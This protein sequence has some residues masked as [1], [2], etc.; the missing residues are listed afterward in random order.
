MRRYHLTLPD[1]DSPM[2]RWVMDLA[3]MLGV[4]YDPNAIADRLAA[5]T[6]RRDSRLPGPG[7]E[8]WRPHSDSAFGQ[9]L[10]HLS[11]F[12]G[13]GEAPGDV[14]RAVFALADRAD[15]R[16]CPECGHPLVEHDDRVAVASGA[17]AHGCQWERRSAAGHRIVCGCPRAFPDAQARDRVHALPVAVPADA[18]VAETTA[19]EPVVYLATTEDAGL[20]DTQGVSATRDG[21]LALLGAAWLRHTANGAPSGAV[22]HLRALGV[23]DPADRQTP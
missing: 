22:P 10:A 11:L 18:V 23:D 1:A 12:L 14:Q 21:G 6:G 4:D 3:T 16:T 9:H 15:G 19:T 17:V 5:V 7:D 8:G 13:C 20:V 2:G